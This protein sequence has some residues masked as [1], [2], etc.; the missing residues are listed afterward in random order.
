MLNHLDRA[1]AEITSSSAGGAPFLASFGLSIGL[2]G[3][4]A[5][6]LPTRTA[7]LI[8]MFQGNLALPL[9]F[10]LERRVAWG[11]MTSDNPLKPLA[12]QLAMSQIAALP[13]VL[14]AFAIEPATTGAAVASV[15]A[16]H[17][18]PYA[19]L[20]RTSIYLWLAPAVSL[21]TMGLVFALGRA[22]LPWSLLY[23]SAIYAVA[24]VLLYRR[25]RMLSA[26]DRRSDHVHATA[27]A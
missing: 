20:H 12:I 23:M 17:L 1:R 19:W 2:T 16:G 11:R 8:L 13:M 24:A 14:L 7:A 10:W 6:W 15:A 21:G 9:A 27:A 22:A 5:F 3:L 4:S 25:A 26:A 18:V